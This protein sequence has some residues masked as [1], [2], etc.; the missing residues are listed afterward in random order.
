MNKEY[1][2]YLLKKNKESYQKIAKDF[3]LTR[4][5]VWEELKIFSDLI[6][7]GDDVLD[8]G[9]GN[10]RLLDIFFGKKIKYT[11]IDSSEELIKEA[12]R[13]FE[14]FSGAPKDREFLVADALN[15]PFYDGSFDKI[16]SIAVLHHIPSLELR[17]KFFLESFRVLKKGGIIVFVVW[18]LKRTDFF[19]KRAKFFVL[20]VLGLSKLDFGDIFIPWGNSGEK[21]YF[22]VFSKREL[23]IL[24]EKA[25][26]VVKECGYLKRGESKANLYLV[27]EKTFNFEAQTVSLKTS[28]IAKNRG[29]GFT[30]AQM[31]QKSG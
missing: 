1:A 29:V 25:G 6:S 9:C 4:N 20:R 14:L 28:D 10:G 31:S 7:D 27:A 15:L 24:A 17:L 22:H 8:L 26:F 16:F 21:R 2:Q 18:N 30:P 3:S 19:R 13:R 23:G 11:G 12:E 5:Y